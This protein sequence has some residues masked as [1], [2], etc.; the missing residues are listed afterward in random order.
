MKHLFVI[1]SLLTA[2]VAAQA[3]V[4]T[5]CGIYRS[6]SSDGML[7]VMRDLLYV[8]TGPSTPAFEIYELAAAGETFSQIE[9]ASQIIQSLIQGQSY[10]LKGEVYQKPNY[11][12]VLVPESIEP[13]QP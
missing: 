13:Y 4:A 6:E 5:V 8:P 12:M 9:D 3:E 1:L 2:G 7:T 10:C 11:Q